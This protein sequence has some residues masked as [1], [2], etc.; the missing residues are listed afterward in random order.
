MGFGTVT[1]KQLDPA[2]QTVFR[3]VV[4]YYH[5]ENIYLSGLTK[6]I[7]TYNSTN[8][9]LSTQSTL[10]NILNPDNPQVNLTAETNNYMQSGLQTSL[11]DKSRLF[12]AMVRSTSRTYEAGQALV[13]V[14]TIAG[15]DNN[16]NITSFIDGGSG[17]ED[18]YKAVIE[19]QPAS[20]FVQTS[21]TGF[22]K[23]ISIYQN[24][25]NQLMR[26]RSASYN[27]QG[28][29][30]Q[31]ITKLNETE[32]NTVT[33][34]YDSYGNLSTIT[35]NDNKNSANTTSYVKNITYDTTINT[36]PTGISNSFNETSSTTYNYLFGI[37][38]YT[39]DKNA[40][41]MR[42]RIDDRGRIV[43]VTGPN[44]LALE[45]SSN[46][47]W[48]IRMQ[49]KG[50]QALANNLDS[51]IYM[52]DASGQFAAVNPGIA[53][54]TNAQHYAVTRHFDP[55]YLTTG[56]TT[57]N[58]MVT[59]SVA[60]GFGRAVQVK[61]TH[62][63]GNDLKWLVSGFEQKDA[64]GRTLKTYLPAVQTPYPA[65]LGT[66]SAADTAY[67][68]V[69]PSSLQPPVEMTYDAKDRAI[70]VKQPGES[71][72]AQI[73]FSIENG[74]LVQ[75]LTNELN[76]TMQTYTDN[77]GRQRKTVQNG[78]L[79]T[80][81]EYNA[82]NELTKVVDNQGAITAYLYDLA[83]RKTEMQHPDRGIVLMKYDKA[84]RMVQQSNSNLQLNGGLMINYL[85]DYNRL[86]NINYPSNPENN[87]KYTYGA[88]GDQMAVTEKAIGRLLYQEDATGV[89]VF[90]YGRMGEVTKNL[91]S[92][93]VAGYQSY[94]F[95]TTWKYDSW[96]RVQ[97]ITYPD[98]EKVSYNYNKAGALQS[99]SSQIPGLSGVQD[100]VSSI[101]YND[102]GER[103]SLTNGNGVV[104]NYTYDT[105]RR[106]KSIA[107]A[108][109]GMNISKKYGYDV[110]SNIKNI[111]T[112]HPQASLPN[113]GEIGG[114][115]VHYY[116]YDNYNRLVHAEGRYTGPS[117][118]G[119][120]YL[121]QDY[122]LNMEYNLDHTIKRK[123]QVH[124]QTITDSYGEGVG[125]EPIMKTNYD[126]QYSDYATG[127]FVAGPNSYGYQQPHAVRTIT[128]S[129]AGVERLAADDPQIRHKQI[130]YDANGNQKEIK[131]KVGELEIS[132]RKN[133]WDEE[134]RLIGV[135]LKPDQRAIHPIAVYTYNAGGE[136]TIRYNMDRMDANS[137]ANRVG[138]D[139]RDNIMIYPNG[140]IMAKVK[141]F[142]EKDIV[143]RLTYTKHYYIG[144]ERVSAK[145]GTVVEL[146]LYPATRLSA[147]LPQMNTTT[148]RNNSTAVVTKAAALVTKTYNYFVQQPPIMNPQTEG[149]QNNYTHDSSKLNVYYFH[150]DH[151]GS[152]SYIT[153]ETGRVSQHMEYMPFGET[154]VDEHINSFNS[155][156]KFNGKEYD[157][158][159]GNYYYG[160]RY[161]DPKLSIFISVDKL[162][163]KGPGISSYAYCFNNPVKLTDPDGNWPDPPFG[164]MLTLGVSY[165]SGGLAFNLTGALGV[166]H[167]TPSFQSQAFLTGSVYYGGNQLGTSSMTRGLQYDITLTGMLTSGKG[168][169]QAH[170]MY[171]I[172][173]NTASP[174]A[175]DFEYSTTYG[176]S[177]NYNSAVNKNWDSN[178]GHR[179]QRSGIVGLKFANFSLQTNNDT[180]TP[181]FFA[182]GGDRAHTG[183]GVLNFGGVEIGYQNFTGAYS[184]TQ[185]PENGGSV[186]FGSL[187]DQNDYQKSLNQSFYFVRSN[188][189]SIEGGPNNG[190]IQNLIHSGTGTGQFDYP[191]NFRVNVGV[192]AEIQGYN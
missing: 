80:T 115:V 150:P 25:S 39:T 88:V 118:A 105:R 40:Q 70:T 89:Q 110:L 139:N 136:R 172:N 120:P 61:K 50:E 102:F 22:P 185:E 149:Q 87:V 31:I 130:L 9:L 24:S 188:G 101:T 21:M 146:G 187:Y 122:S 13:T 10:Y 79:T 113:P 171:S 77:R 98:Q 164:G 114:P 15:Y 94:W 85:Y 42:T 44:E 35:E 103:T 63:S 153:N 36:Y 152:S 8:Q 160:A 62:K 131:E 158:E 2:S 27:T 174:F 12:V 143:Y 104:T 123:T 154:L 64:Y 135:D 86:T 17:S 129:P 72:A 5:N 186:A 3:S 38:V 46:K 60:D 180:K 48:T 91:R 179:I 168:T 83:G 191:G 177:L 112:E 53:N 73:N 175:N 96:N 165:G 125:G 181:P 81:F 26:Q 167:R 145:T 92:V 18:T 170:K 132:L 184:R 6:E 151:L 144:T 67:F 106:L 52:V 51:A 71:Q 124:T 126:L 82:I 128:E 173:Y 155:P 55:E 141:R 161:Y 176:Q 133:Q 166:Q 47:A 37:P 107:H 100:V 34:A 20:S 121:Q 142:K 109:T 97:E 162:A 93:A 183:G 66:Y 54:P 157:E 28:S 68:S 29:M 95:Y 1:T 178:Y 45:T 137:N 156:F 32:D 127:A 76:Q 33:L 163:E 75:K 56:T 147:E 14:K 30:T 90:G 182:D 117:D 58:E 84:G 159:T 138:Q 16:G 7:A 134:N 74:M 190:G 148:I 43:E 57:T 111:G 108:F 49:Y 59:I 189:L 78:E 116:D 169:G 140:L 4:N 23:K 19:Y 119:T 69:A 11:L 192:S 99:V 65:T 41:S